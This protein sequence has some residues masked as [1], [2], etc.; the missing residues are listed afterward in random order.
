MGDNRFIKS[1]V[2][3]VKTKGAKEFSFTVRGATDTPTEGKYNATL[4][5]LDAV[6]IFKV[7]DW[8]LKKPSGNISI[9]YHKGFLFLKKSF[10]CK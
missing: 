10:F 1:G 8:S 3:N 2:R 5:D 6:E 7:S 4:D 9:L